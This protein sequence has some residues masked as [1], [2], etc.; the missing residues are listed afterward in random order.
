MSRK[1][2]V[3]RLDDQ[4]TPTKVGMCKN[5]SEQEFAADAWSTNNKSYLGVTV[6]QEL[7]RSHFELDRLK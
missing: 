5:F 6:Q 2:L 1:T 4:Y 3:K 7:S